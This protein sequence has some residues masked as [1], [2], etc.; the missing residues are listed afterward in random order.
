MDLGALGLWTFMIGVAVPKNVYN[1][2]FA[3]SF[4]GASVTDN[5]ALLCPFNYFK[6]N[7]QTK[8]KQK[9]KKIHT[10]FFTL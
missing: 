3:F 2:V 1:K 10:P 7:F 6:I 5:N 4:L 8:L 9:F